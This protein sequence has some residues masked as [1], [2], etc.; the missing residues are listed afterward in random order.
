MRP[1]M[2]N[3]EFEGAETLS[4]LVRFI[5][6]LKA[7]EQSALTSIYYPLFFHF[8]APLSLTHCL[9]LTLFV[10]TILSVP[11]HHPDPFPKLACKNRDMVVG[12]SAC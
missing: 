3:L 6:G 1:H 5:C 11:V 10:S 12:K 8:F 4:W 7:V 9:S 2:V